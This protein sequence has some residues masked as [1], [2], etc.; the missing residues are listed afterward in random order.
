MTVPLCV[1]GLRMR[2]NYSSLDLLF[3]WI[4]PKEYK[5]EFYSK[6]CCHFLCLETKKDNQRKFKANPNA[7][8]CFARPAHNN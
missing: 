7:S 8:G 5:L 2:S 3:I 6:L 1:G 4:K